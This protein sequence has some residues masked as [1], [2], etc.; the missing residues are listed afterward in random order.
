[1]KDLYKILLNKIENKRNS[2]FKFTGYQLN[3]QL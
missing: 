1:M 2:V 3:L